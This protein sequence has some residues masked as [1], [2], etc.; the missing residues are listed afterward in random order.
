MPP[1]WMICWAISV[2]VRMR[3]NPEAE[4]KETMHLLPEAVTLKTT[5]LLALISV[6]MQDRLSQPSKAA[7]TMRRRTPGKY[8]PYAL[9]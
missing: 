5:V 4:Q 8:A 7:F 6:T 3:R 2:P 1:G 9:N